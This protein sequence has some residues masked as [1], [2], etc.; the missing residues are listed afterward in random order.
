MDYDQ[1][2]E[3]IRKYVYWV[4]EDEHKEGD[5]EVFLDSGAGVAPK[6]DYNTALYNL[7][8]LLD[9][10]QRHSNPGFENLDL[11]RLAAKRY[12][13]TVWDDD[14]LMRDPNE[15]IDGTGA[16]YVRNFS[17]AVDEMR[18]AL[19]AVPSGIMVTLDAGTDGLS[20]KARDYVHTEWIRRGLS[21]EP[22]DFID[23]PGTAA[24]QK[25]DRAEY[26]LRRGL[27]KHKK[28][29]LSPDVS[30]TELRKAARDYVYTAWDDDDLMKAPDYFIAKGDGVVP[31]G[32]YDDAID[33]LNTELDKVQKSQIQMSPDGNDP[34]Q[35]KDQSSAP[36]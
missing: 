11:L 30:E 25:I 23:G 6:D 29:E 27:D 15:L 21:G 10:W 17:R 22:Q 9:N 14:D 12:V 20:Q 36:D 33:E 24:L 8:T 26:D 5:P 2:R 35:D 32:I 13:Y 28:P 34:N 31:L 18:G 16:A 4:W 7:K 1:A 19:D 3:G